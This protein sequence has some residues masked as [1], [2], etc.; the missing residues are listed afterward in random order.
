MRSNKQALIDYK[1]G[2]CSV[3]GYNK[4][5]GALD[6]HHVAEKS[7]SIAASICI[8][9]SGPKALEKMKK[10]ADKTILVCKNCH[11]EIHAKQL[12]QDTLMK[13]QMHA[14][15]GIAAINHIAAKDT[16]HL[17]EG[18]TNCASSLK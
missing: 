2:K 11:A 8:M 12:K 16:E 13:P 18:T 17:R 10:E 3:C 4:C 1:G 5:N 7:F 15:A 9:G 14:K 6:F